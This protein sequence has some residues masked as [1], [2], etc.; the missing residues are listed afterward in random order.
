MNVL[1]IA[2]YFP[3]DLG[4]AATRAYNV[5]EGLLLNGCR[6]TVV[7]AFPHYPYGK[8]PEKYRWKPIQVEQLGGIRLIRTFM[9][10]ITSK[11][12]SNR[13]LLMGF[14]A[15]TS[16]FALPWVGKVDA[17][18]ATSW[19]PGVAI[20]KV[21]R[22]PVTFNVDDLTVEDVVSL[23]LLSKN[24]LIVKLAER[25]YRF[26]YTKANAVTPISP[27]YVETISRKYC[28]D[29]SRIHV[30]RGGVD[31][32]IFKGT[33]RGRRA[34]QKFI[35]LYAGVLGVGYDFEQIFRAAKILEEKE[36]DV[37]FIIHG[38]G[39]CLGYI[40]NRIAE[41]NLTNV[42]LSDKIFGSRREV[43]QLLSEAD[44]LI[45]PMKAFGRPYLG[46]AA[47]LYEYQAAEKPI[48]SCGD[49]QP[50][51]YIRETGSGIALKPG[52]PEAL[53]QA[54]VYLKENPKVAQQMAKMGRKYA[55]S[56]LSVEII[57]SKVMGI[58]EALNKR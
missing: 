17:I 20:G 54:I 46:I 25:V 11:G 35:V 40:K 52:D 12:F 31:L 13:L 23:G 45:L 49:G 50:A 42:K 57:G 5:A 27:G 18:W 14:F 53:A 58:F 34:G 8:I 6:V 26:W 28:V 29:R 30:V 24:S 9:P 21:K 51:A 16:L 3:P 43:M 41:L 22:K 32:S 47:K 2:Q 1:V 37:E 39:E 48:I 4:G 55:E 7:A 15:I 38:G 56:N 10:P 33:T 44:V 19:V 36:R